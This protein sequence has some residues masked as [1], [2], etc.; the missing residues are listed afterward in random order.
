[1]KCKMFIPSLDIYFK[2]Y[3]DI[4]NFELMDSV[5]ISILGKN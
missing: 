3:D 2:I 5:A 1:M 4:Y